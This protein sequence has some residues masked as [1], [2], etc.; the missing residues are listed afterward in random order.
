[1]DVRFE[2]L[3]YSSIRIGHF[4]FGDSWTDLLKR[5]QVI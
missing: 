3:L 5:D 4:E 2:H 1:L